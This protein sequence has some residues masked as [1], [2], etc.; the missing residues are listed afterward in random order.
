M[1]KTIA[2]MLLSA[3][4]MA[5]QLPDQDSTQLPPA[6]N[7]AGS[8]ETNSHSDDPGFIHGLPAEL[9]LKASICA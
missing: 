2:L 4:A 1:M 8:A 3:A 5:S 6:D 7:A 9:F